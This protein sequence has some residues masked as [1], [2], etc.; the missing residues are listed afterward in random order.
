MTKTMA[1]LW[2]GNLEPIRYL[3]K[4]NTEIKDLERLIERSLE[5]FDDNLNEKQKETFEN[6]NDCINE[7]I[8]ATSEQAFCDG[9]CLAIKIFTEALNGAEEII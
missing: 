3:G 1:Q 5:K 6:Y 2:Y 4:N 8:I 9:F 7:Y